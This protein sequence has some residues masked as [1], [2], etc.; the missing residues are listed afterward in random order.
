[1]KPVTMNA[2]MLRMILI[3]VML[4]I[5]GLTVGGFYFAQG[6]LREYA[7][8]ISVLK[9]DAEASSS[10]VQLYRTIENK[11]DEEKNT[12]AEAKEIVAESQEYQYQD[13]I[14]RDLTQISRDTGVVIT[15]F[16]F[17][18]TEAT[19]T[20]PGAAPVA[21]PPT[22]GTTPSA[23]PQAAGAGAL[24]SRKVDVAIQSPLDYNT[25]M[26]FIRKIE[27]NKLKMQIASVSLAKG[28]GNEVTSQ[29]FSIEVYVQ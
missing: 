28:D 19:P 23:T 20:T 24:N 12:I 29:S 15:G 8:S 5:V 11:L 27:Q 16:T 13:Q 2:S 21:T 10:N 1:M 9:A 6:K 7:T 17:S 26:N 3:V 18:E 4:L 25:I 22:T 14:V